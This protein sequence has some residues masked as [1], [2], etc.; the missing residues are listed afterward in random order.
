MFL[1]KLTDNLDKTKTVFT[2]TLLL[3]TLSN[4]YDIYIKGLMIVVCMAALLIPKL[5][6]VKATW[7]LIFLIFAVGNIRHYLEI[8]N[9][10]FLYIY[11]SLAVFL[12][13]F[14]DNVEGYLKINAKLMIG[15]SFSIA[16][17]W[18]LF[19]EDYLNGSFFLWTCLT[20]GRLTK[21][22]S[23]FHIISKDVIEQNKNAIHYLVYAAP[24]P[25]YKQLIQP[26][27][28]NFIAKFFT[29]GGIIMEAIVAALFLLPQKLSITRYRDYPLFLFIII[30]Y[31]IAPVWEF[32]SILSILGMAQTDSKRNVIYYMMLFLLMQ[33][34]RIILFHFL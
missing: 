5:Q 13:L 6:T 3:F 4:S 15:L 25:Y 33:L 17:I 24:T 11:W 31:I 32:G 1:D 16:F 27:G 7:L 8:D 2:A 12:C 14:T 10:K 21:F 18:K 30:V 29:Y 22:L 19:S 20:D 9:H 28:V 34:Y 23:F 26:H